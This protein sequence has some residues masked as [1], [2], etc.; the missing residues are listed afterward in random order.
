MGLEQH[1]SKLNKN[2]RIFNCP[3]KILNSKRLA[4]AFSSET[5]LK[6]ILNLC[7]KFYLKKKSISFVN[8]GYNSFYFLLLEFDQIN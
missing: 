8:V 7:L 6:D 5:I 1:E 3:F 4:L 2:H